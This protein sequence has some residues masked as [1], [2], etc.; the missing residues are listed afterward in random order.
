MTTTTT[1]NIE[2]GTAFWLLIAVVISG[3]ILYSKLGSEG[4][5]KVL[6]GGL[7]DA[8]GR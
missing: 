5:S 7:S 6:S 8:F 3:L 2:L 4:M 1:V